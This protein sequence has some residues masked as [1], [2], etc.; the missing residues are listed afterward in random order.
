MRRILDFG[1]VSANQNP[2]SDPI[3]AQIEHELPTAPA[4]AFVPSAAKLRD[5]SQ[6]TKGSPD[7]RGSTSRTTRG[8]ITDTNTSLVDGSE[9]SAVRPMIRRKSSLTSIKMPKKGSGRA[10]LPGATV[11]R[12]SS[13]NVMTDATM[14]RTNKVEDPDD[15][16]LFGHR[17]IEIHDNIG[18]SIDD[19]L[20]RR[21]DQAR[22][23]EQTLQLLFAAEVLLFVEYMEVFMPLLYAACIGG[24][25][26]LPNARY[27]VM[28]MNMSYD[29][30]VLEVLTSMATP[31]WRSCRSC[32][33]TI[34]SRRS[35]A[36]RRSTS[37]RSCSSRTP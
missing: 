2:Q 1:Q 26:N 15:E 10:I 30:V 19:I 25:W 37:S 34:S 33:C 16:R 20:I 32:P 21:K 22:I 28:L 9:A 17:G 13:S 7:R 3:N 14:P 36:S 6:V 8:S 31:C 12:M 18:V 27:N 23:L 11:R 4:T 5:D 29:A 35:T 24:L